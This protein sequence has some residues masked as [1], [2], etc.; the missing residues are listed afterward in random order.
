M[1][2]INLH[3]HVSIQFERIRKK[4]IMQYISSYSKI[5]LKL[6][7]QKFGTNLTSITQELLQ[8]IQD[9]NLRAKIDAVDKVI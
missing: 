5:D 3:S 9:G 7:A 8:L 4:A 6:M 2:D 1:L